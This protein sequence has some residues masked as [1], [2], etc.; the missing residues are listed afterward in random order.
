MEVVVDKLEVAVAKSKE[1]V[2]EII[3]RV[4]V[5]LDKLI[6]VIECIRN[7]GLR[8]NNKSKTLP[9]SNLTL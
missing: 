9:A 3:M 1:V 2:V 4:P 5:Y 6:Q 7:Q 8:L